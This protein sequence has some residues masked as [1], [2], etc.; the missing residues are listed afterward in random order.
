LEAPLSAG[1][2]Y[3]NEM[4]VLC[5]SAGDHLEGI[6]AFNEKRPAEFTR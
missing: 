5:F 1:L 3:E 4:N 6:R 2:A